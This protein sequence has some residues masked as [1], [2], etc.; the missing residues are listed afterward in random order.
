M[1]L[2]DAVVVGSGLAGTFAAYGL[3]GRD[4]LVLDVGFRPPGVPPLEGNL[5]E[6]RKRQKDLFVPLIGEHFESLH[7]I[8]QPAISL[9]LKAPFMSYIVRDAERLAPWS[10]TNFEGV[11]SFAQGGLANAWGAGVYRFTHKDLEEFPIGPEDLTP[12]YDELTA[13]IGVSGAND[14]LAEFFG[15]E[16]NLLPP[17]RLSRFAGEV[18]QKYNAR[19]EGFNRQGIFIGYPRLAVLTQPHNGRPAYQYD[20]LEFFKPYNPAIYNPV[21]TLND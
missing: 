14:G 3:R 9:K 11:M 5:Y 6:I 21:F 15:N 20:N 13:H 8:H 1:A 10:A 4:V 12:Y 7:N 16:P 18:L 19:R 17:L 2:R